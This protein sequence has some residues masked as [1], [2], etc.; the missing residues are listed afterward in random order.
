MRLTPNAWFTGCIFACALAFQCLLAVPTLG[1]ASFTGTILGTVTDP[2]GAV[3]SNAKVIV[4]NL[5]TNET[6]MTA[7]NEAG[8][9]FAPN[10]KPG[11]Y[12]VEVTAAGFKRFVQD[13]LPL[14]LDQRARIDARLELG[15]PAET[16]VISEA[17]PVLQTESGTL[18][19]VI[20]NRQIV[21]LPLNGRGAFSL[22]GLVA[23][24]AEGPNANTSGAAAR[25]NGG[26]N[27]LNEVQLDGVTAINVKGGSVGYTPMVDALQEF[28]VVTNSFSAEYGRT[29]GGVILA[30]IKSGGNYFHGVLFEFLRNDALNARNLFARPQDPKPILRQNQ[31]GFALGGPLRRDRTF[32]FLDWQGTRIRNAAVNTSAGPT[33]RLRNGDFRGLSTIYDPATTRI[34]NNQVVRD[35]FPNNIIP[36]DRLDPAA[37]KILQFYPLPNGAGLANNY[38]LA[39]GGRSDADQGDLRIDHD[40]SNNVKLMGR[41]SLNNSISTPS[42]AFLTA[43]NPANYPARGR[44]QNAV[45]SYLHTLSPTLI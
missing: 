14:Q 19:Q 27:R 32:F 21:T 29:G 16:V 7:T 13:K 1:Q 40:L 36:R 15:S 44:Q 22:I 31:F 33:E 5:A 2:N 25:I 10:L 30:T 42:P 45:I 23:G 28:K 41:Y 37:L 18:G 39:S 38:V 24:V 11:S 4:V 12:R 6:A 34:V 8:N 43:G 9:Y 35:P 26:R 20:D 17:A 3:V